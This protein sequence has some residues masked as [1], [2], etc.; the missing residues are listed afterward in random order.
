M[1]HKFSHQKIHILI[2]M[3]LKSGYIF[4]KPMEIVN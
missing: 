1:I 4:I 2:K 3:D